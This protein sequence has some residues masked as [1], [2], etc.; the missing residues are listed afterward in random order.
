MSF[1]SQGTGKLE[2][3]MH[4]QYIWENISKGELTSPQNRKVSLDWG[5]RLGENGGQLGH[6]LQDSK[7]KQKSIKG[8]SA[9]T[10]VS[11]V[12]QYCLGA[13]R[14]AVDITESICHVPCITWAKTPGG[15]ALTG[16]N[17]PPL[18][19]KGMPSGLWA[20]VPSTLTHPP[21][22]GPRDHHPV[23]IWAS[24]TH[25]FARRVGSSSVAT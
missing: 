16:V 15:N 2:G 11:T 8:G 7:T 10:W 3:L 22:V 17:I 14:R 6:N 19:A 24:T 9:S 18:T 21:T 13:T 4:R 25:S 5:L 23:T 1:K 20:W 12:L